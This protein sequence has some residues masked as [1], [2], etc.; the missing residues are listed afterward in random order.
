[1]RL[2][3]L[4]CLIALAMLASAQDPVYSLRH[5]GTEDGL[6][7]RLVRGITEDH[8][9]FIW[10]ATPKGVARFDGQRF[11]V[12]TRADGLY[13]DYAAQVLLGPEGML[14]VTYG[15]GSVRGTVPAIDLIDPETWTVTSFADRFGAHAPCRA[16]DIA[17]VRQD[18]RGEIVLSTLQGDAIVYAGG[19]TFRR[20]Q[21][22]DGSK[23]LN[24]VPVKKGFAGVRR[25]PGE[26]DIIHLMASDGAT[27]S[28]LLLPCAVEQ[29]PMAD[30]VRDGIHYISS[31][32]D[33]ERE[34]F[35]LAPDG[36][37][38]QTGPIHLRGQWVTAVRIP[39]AADEML[40][41]AAVR[42][43]TDAKCD[44][45]APLV[46]N[47]AAEFPTI[48]ATM[49]SVFHDRYGRLWLGTTFGLYE[50]TRKPTA[51]KRMLYQQSTPQ[52]FGIQI[53]GMCA[54]DS[55]LYVNTEGNGLYALNAR[56]GAVLAVD[57][58]HVWRCA[59]V[60]DDDGTL[61]GWEGKAIVHRRSS[62]LKVLDRYPL[63]PDVG[64]VW[65]LKRLDAHRWLMGAENG[66]RVLDT[67]T[68][69]TTLFDRSGTMGRLDSALVEFIGR[70]AHY[71][72]WAC[73]ENGF[74]RLGVSSLLEHWCTTDPIH[75]L[76]VDHILCFLEDGSGIFWLGTRDGGLL[77]LDRE[78]GTV[79][80]FGTE[81]GLP[82]NTVYAIMEGRQGHLWASTDHGLV[83][84]DPAKGVETTF[85]SG[86]G[87]G[88][89]EFNR[90]A[91]A[92]GPDGRMFFGGL[93]GI[94]AFLPDDIDASQHVQQAELV[95][96]SF[97]QYD[98]SLD[99]VVDRTV[100]VART[101]H[102]TV[103]PGDRYFQLD[104]ALLS[105]T[106]PASTTYGWRIDGVDAGWNEQH[107][108]DLIIRQLPY[109]D[110]RLRL[111]ARV[112]NGLWEAKD[113]LLTVSVLRP[114]YLTWWFI[115]MAL[116]IIAAG[117]IVLF[118]YRLAQ[119]RRVFAVRDRIAADLHDEIG[120]TLSSV[121]LYGAVARQ[122]SAD[123]ESAALLDR[124]TEGTT[125]ALES[126][127]DIVWSVN[128]RFDGV[129][130]LFDRMRA[131]AVR[132]AEEHEFE[133][134]FSFSGNVEE[135]KLDME[136]RKN[137][138]LF[139]REA[140]HNVAKHAACSSL[141]VVLTAE[142]H[143]L[144]VHIA[145]DGRGMPTT[146]GDASYA[147][148]GNGL[149]TMHKR[150]DALNGRMEFHSEAGQGTTVTLEVPL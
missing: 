55:F 78:K 144:K 31:G 14:W 56:T 92:Q 111:K 10:L 35:W 37:L 29:M 133:L 82:D 134:R 110:W 121:A 131:F 139:F 61:W 30:P 33:R 115:A 11:K 75:H 136:Q 122:R 129:D 132:T 79:R 23:S 3:L 93:N 54:R 46:F 116:L 102:I 48:D 106:E 135:L 13:S 41:D 117:V 66:L 60:M 91:Y 80:S 21:A 9:G 96:S 77:R 94:T 84:F 63:P 15:R 101:R 4:P 118:R 2:F 105:F 67:R 71:G 59:L 5:F 95:I 104:M 103:H 140:V 27:L 124:I 147:M 68:R 65:S 38:H 22:A 64:A 146:E 127:N 39:L 86:D 51:F 112:G 47:L 148:G 107:D 100:E 18:S 70:D 73:S 141:E 72:I 16:V 87:I 90:T 69:S 52:G 25:G 74:Y 150:A 58:A 125:A 123:A 24:W 57:T 7:D 53:R 142:R 108:N 28:D 149:I 98:A 83:D 26:T 42:K 43:G 97:R 49:R 1:M 119:A 138:Y 89:D 6:P 44:E 36:Q 76:P 88:Q 62:D 137:L 40:V 113:L 45:N 126:M 130:H 8:Q 12:W 17:S 19:N 32:E 128:S 85:R 114:F 145:D 20:I 120:S 143:R 99:S 109:G 34:G 81:D 50:L